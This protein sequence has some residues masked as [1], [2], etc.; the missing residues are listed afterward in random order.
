M[1][2]IFYAGAA[3]IDITPPLGTIL[4]V[5][6][7]PH[8]ARFIHDPLHAKALVLK[9]GN[10]L[11]AIVIVDICIMGTD[12]IDEIKSLIYKQSRIH[13]ENILLASNHN[14]ASGNVVGLLG[15]AVDI[16]Y[17][18]KLPGL[19]VEAVKTAKE[20]LK[21]AKMCSGS[22]D[23][24][25]YVLS[26]RYKMKAGY[27]AKNPVTH[28]NDMVK[29]NPFGLEHL[30]EGPT[31]IPDP[32]LSFLAI[33]GLDERWIT[34][35][36]NYSLHYVGDWHVDSVT[37]DY[38]GEFSRQI[39]EKLNADDDFI[40]IMSNGTSGDIN[41]WDFMHPD[42][43]PKENFAKSKLIGGD[44]AHKVFEELINV[45]WQKDPEI[46]V[47]YEEL[48][49]EIRKPSH[50][51]LEA[52]KKSFIDNDFDNLSLKKDIT[53]RIYNREQLLLNEYPNTS[54][55][56]IQA[57]KIGNLVIGA[58][59]G[60]FFAETGIKLKKSISSSN[61]FS[62]CLANAYG[63]Y[64]PPSYEMER[65]GYET[66]RARSSFLEPNAEKNIRERLS[67]LILELLKKH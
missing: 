37:S 56:P 42:R 2:N 53:Q 20:K 14:H 28:K 6:Y 34:V 38:F 7:L 16:A 52:A 39:H 63:G 59:P 58:L 21:P 29:T 62:I 35:L 47:Q 54:R 12:F 32:G 40:G 31:S 5:D 49:I 19:V 11:I 60:E 18:N 23:V 48:E 33:K 30:I 17:R 26:R 15:G 43:F 10:L 46:A 22:V 45:Q 57:I 51:E 8:Y 61:Y 55:S 9:K 44:L 41:I 66:W 64:I 67:K 50:Q 25:E 3:K 4:G 24:P 1:D 27:K 13:P 65:G 36:G